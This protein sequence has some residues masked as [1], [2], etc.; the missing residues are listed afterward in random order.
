LPLIC[1][2]VENCV[3]ESN[4]KEKPVMAPEAMGDTA[5][6]PVIS[7]VGTVEIPVFARMA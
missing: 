5:M 2:D 1:E 7:E 3:E 6:S 4:V